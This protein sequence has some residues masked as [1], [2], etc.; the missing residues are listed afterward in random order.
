M[1]KFVFIALILPLLLLGGCGSK[2]IAYSEMTR[3]SQ[4][5]GGNLSF[6]FDN[7]THTAY[8][9]GQGEIIEKY[10]IDISRN[11]LES[12]NRVGL[13]IT[14]P[15]NITDHESGWAKLNNEKIEGGTFYSIV[16]GKR[17]NAAM[18]YPAVSADV[19]RIELT[20]VWQD[21]IKPQEYTIVI[22]DGTSFAI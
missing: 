6:E 1:K 4:N 21:G 5:I 14:A 20:I 15:I 7:I 16:N 10:D 11:W 17:T 13:Q 8:L 3:D 12:A 9:G 22:R 18:F 19:Q 2:D